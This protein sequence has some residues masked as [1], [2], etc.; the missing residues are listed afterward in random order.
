LEV[1]RQGLLIVDLEQQVQDEKKILQQICD[2]KIQDEAF[3][4]FQDA[5]IEKLEAKV[6]ENNNKYVAQDKIKEL[7]VV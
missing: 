3:V 6:E 5:V 7:K 4:A 1:T 2:A